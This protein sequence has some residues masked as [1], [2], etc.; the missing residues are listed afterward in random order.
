[1]KQKV[2]S[3]AEE[4]LA[5]TVAVRHEL[6]KI[7]ELAG[8]EFRTA[9]YLRKKLE[10]LP[11]EV[12]RPCL[13]TDVVALIHGKR[14]GPNI[15]LR[16]DIDGLPIQEKNSV[17]Y[18]SIQEGRMHACAHDGHS[19]MLF[20]AAS[21][22]CRLRDSFPGT[23]RILFQP[24]EEMAAMAK[25]LIE[26]GAIDDPFPDFVA[27][28][29][30]WPGVKYGKI[31]TREGTVM[32]AGGYFRLT[33]QS[34]RYFGGDLIGLAGRV[35]AELRKRW[36][37][38]GTLKFSRVQSGARAFTV[39][40]K[41]FLEGIIG[42]FSD[43]TA[44]KAKAG[45]EALLSGICGKTGVRWTLEFTMTYPA[46]VVPEEGARLAKQAAEKYLGKGSFLPMRKPCPRN[47]DFAFFLRRCKGV[48][49]HLGMGDS[50]PLH[51]PLFDFDDQLLK[52]GMVFLAGL[53]MDFL[54]R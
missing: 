42:F 25:Y 34:P 46:A 8:Q 54:N 6:H 15:T 18:R 23:V 22:L 30:A 20:G 5:E 52:T 50:R 47:D 40:R 17:P 21:V 16:A 13:N 36:P 43:A 11:L 51:D 10:A 49:C 44:E 38:D 39:S 12:Q 35:I 48:Y 1:M 19:A 41:L 2:L 33:L 37:E 53:S 9:E 27:A 29:H 26:A 7:P 24:G 3:L 28:L 32:G 14:S 31:S 45:L 4:V